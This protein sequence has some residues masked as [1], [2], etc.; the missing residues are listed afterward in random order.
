MQHA[1]LVDLLLKGALEFLSNEG[2]RKPPRR[3]IRG[4]NSI[5][6]AV[7][8]YLDHCR[9]R[10]LSPKSIAGYDSTLRRVFLPWCDREGITKLDQL[11]TRALEKLAAALLT[12]GG[13]GKTKLSPFSVH[14]YLRV[15]KQLLTWASKNDMSVTGVVPLPRTPRPLVNVLSREEIQKLEDAATDDRDKLIVRL[16]ADTGLRVGELCKLRT[17]D[18]VERGRYHF[19][20]VKGKGA[21]DRLVPVLPALYRRLQR[22]NEHANR[23]ELET[24]RLFISR[25]RR[26]RGDFAPLRESGVS[27][28]ISNLAK[29]ARM[30]RRVYAHLLRHSFATW[31]LQRGTN[32]IM[33]KDILGHSSLVMIESTYAHLSPTDAYDAMA[34][35][36]LRDDD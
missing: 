5:E 20:H 34:K 14:A 11:S 23:R 35:A 8:D 15:V 2:G 19:L 3:T 27:Q 31:Q 16:L 24:D 9:S 22:H 18:L 26:P 32:P 10:N 21:R 36:L 4:M 13:A 1:Q 28:M 7:N 33:L 25:R 30:D 12:K 6:R 17:T 29:T